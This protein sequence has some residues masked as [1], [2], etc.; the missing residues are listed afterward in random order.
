MSGAAAP[1]LRLGLQL[2]IQAQSTIFVEDWERDAGPDEMAAIARR[3]D[4]LGFDYLGVCDHAVIP[5]SRADRMGTTWYDTVAT[6]SWL[7]GITERVRLLSHV[8]VLPA[9][10]PLIAAKQFATLDRLSGGRAIMGVGVGHVVEEF[11]LRRVDFDMRGIVADEAI[12]VVRKAFIDEWV[13]HDGDVFHVHEL[14]IAP[15]PV[16]QPIPIWVGGSSRRALRRAAEHGDGWIPQGTPRD[17]MPAQIATIREL[18]ERSELADRQIDL[19]AMAEPLYV[20]DPGWDVGRWTLTGGP[21]EHAER[22][23]A[24]AEMGCGHVQVRVR[25]RSA[26]E[27]IDQLERVATEVAPLLG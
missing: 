7:A 16:Q 14:A 3:A 21:D 15:R 2:P 1:R 5:R 13:D 6:L 18:R 9:R 17:Q 20:G 12:E 10:H 4:E 23:R 22:L 19:G 24:F 8:Y 27:Y 26:D 25:S 11:A